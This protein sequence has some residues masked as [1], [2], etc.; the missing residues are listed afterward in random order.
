MGE[1][2]KKVFISYAWETDEDNRVLRLAQKLISDGI[3]VVFDKWDLQP[4]QDIYYFM[5]S[6]IRDPEIDKVLIICDKHYKD[7][8]D[9]RQGGVGNE[10]SIVSRE[11]YCSVSQEK[12]IPILFEKD[13][14]NKEYIPVYLSALLYID[15]CDGNL[16]GEQ[17]IK[18]IRHIYNE[19]EYI[20]PPLGKKPDFTKIKK[21]TSS[22]SNCKSSI[23]NLYNVPLK[24][25]LFTGRSKKLEELEEK[26]ENA[27]IVI[28]KGIAGVGKTQIVK[29]YI[30]AHQKNYRYIYW[31]RADKKMI[32]D[33]EYE[34]LLKY[35]G[36]EYK[37]RNQKVNK[38]RVKKHIEDLENCLVIYDNADE[39][40]I[41]D[42]IEYMPRSGKIIVTTTN[43]LW[44]S[45]RYLC[46][47]VKDFEEDEAKK[48]L[49]NGTISREKND[50]DCADV[51]ILGKL[52]RYY[53]LAL[54]HAR[55][56]IN[57]RRITFT[58]YI[59][60][61]NECSYKVMQNKIDEYKLTVLKAFSIT[62]EKINSRSF[63]LLS[64]CAVL[65]NNR[66][67]INE[68]F[69][70]SGLY[71]R[72]SID[73]SIDE[74]AQY[75]LVEQEGN[76]LSIHGVLQE[77]LRVEL[78]N[79]DTYLNILMEMEKTA[80]S[81]ISKD[82]VKSIA[83]NKK[84]GVILPHLIALI[85]QNELKDIDLEGYVELCFYT[86]HILYSFG[87][88]RDAISYYDKSLNNLD[89][90][91]NETKLAGILGNIGISYY[92]CGD[93]NRA[94]SILEESRKKAEAINNEEILSNALGNMSIVYKFQGIPQKALEYV[95]KAL[96]LAYKIGNFNSIGSQLLNKGNIYKLMGKDEDALQVFKRVLELSKENNDKSLEMKALGSIGIMLMRAYTDSNKDK[97]KLVCSIEKF[98]ASLEISIE[99]KDKR[100][101]AINLDYLG[102][103]YYKLKVYKK[104][105]KY[106][107]KAISIVS[108][109]D[110]KQYKANSLL[111]RGLCYLDM[112]RKDKA[113]SDLDEA[114]IIAK[115]IEHKEV[116]D[117]C[118]KY[119]NDI[120][121][122]EL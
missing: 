18:L 53:P 56:Y 119:I 82:N 16:E 9:Q 35:V 52:L 45:S 43:D 97:E 12:F 34:N 42:L 99:L 121:N 27:N 68:F 22:V 64:K 14:S 54:E 92:Y 103:C 55:A 104:A 74:L 86:G 80:L 113:K 107:D 118:T 117:Q 32:L 70:S 101:E 89:S 1:K 13:K 71:N 72:I 85:G 79:N 6:M 87:N 24:N 105:I 110:L 84:N 39:I 59:K 66:I 61:F 116:I 51:M 57:Y 78:K 11:V 88:A 65:A 108:E 63:G 60:L 94:L 20:K 120:E 98:N 83:E 37:E 122:S 17:Y 29:E 47:K 73:E 30:Y 69:I 15:L 7:K 25:P 115:C 58:D 10:T 77:I 40:E 112:C 93:C 114:L 41:D 44:D 90:I 46:I 19:P 33:K 91:N 23:A 109:L 3:D 5:E 111:N 50:T 38:E 4:G 100:T 28:L 26:V 81:I 67:P 102:S 49:L 95:D 8:A 76:F 96:V 62:F 75:S 21:E 106:L 48:F 31:L 2:Q 36:I